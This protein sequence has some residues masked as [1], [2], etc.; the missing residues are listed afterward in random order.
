[1]GFGLVSG[2]LGGGFK[3]MEI[4]S[5]LGAVEMGNSKIEYHNTAYAEEGRETAR[6][7]L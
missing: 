2:N 5:V 6:L 3:E 7:D 4:R 1:M